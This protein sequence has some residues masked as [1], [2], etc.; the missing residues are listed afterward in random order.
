M[1]HCPYVGGRGR[2]VVGQQR[3][4]CSASQVRTNPRSASA[5][6]PRAHPC[7]PRPHLGRT[8]SGRRGLPART[9]KAMSPRGPRSSGPNPRIWQTSLNHFLQSSL[10]FFLLSISSFSM[11]NKTPFS[12]PFWSPISTDK[13][14]LKLF[15]DEVPPIRPL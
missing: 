13:G 2:P 7:S 6:P 15:R 4:F 11:L 1:E 5:A 10:P 9:G 14:L 3:W 12:H 8:R